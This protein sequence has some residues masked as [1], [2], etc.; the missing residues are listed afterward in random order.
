M[1]KKS[2]FFGLNVDKI[3]SNYVVGLI[4]TGFG[5]LFISLVASDL[6]IYAKIILF[7]LGILLQ[8]PLIKIFSEKSTNHKP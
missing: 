4:C 2:N 3:F 6:H 8:L 5:I 7:V 1:E